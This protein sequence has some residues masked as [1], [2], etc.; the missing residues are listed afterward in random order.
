MECAYGIDIGNYKIVISE[1]YITNNYVSI[2]ENELS[3]KEF[4]YFINIIIQL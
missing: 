1:V 2:A 3:K 4:T